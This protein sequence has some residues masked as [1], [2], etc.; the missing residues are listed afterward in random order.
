MT[1]KDFVQVYYPFA[2]ESEAKT[3]IDARF[4]LAQAALETGWGKSAPGNMFFGI[5]ADPR[6][7]PESERQLLTTSEVLSDDKQG[8]RFPVLIS[9]TPRPDGKY[10][11][12]VKDWFRKYKTPE[13]S[14]TD[15]GNF[16]FANKRYAKALEVRHDPYLFAEG[17]AAAGYATAPDYA[18]TLKSI[19]RN[20]EKNIPV[21]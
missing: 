17:I 12:R 18:A 7:Y 20:I 3:G 15:H 1:P 21:Q 8:A 6:K 16:F 2:K 11:Y 9:I 13:G 10:L 5:K 4:T 14:F 19:I